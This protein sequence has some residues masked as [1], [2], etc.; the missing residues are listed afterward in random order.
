M[1]LFSLG[2]RQFRLEGKP[3][4]GRMLAEIPEVCLGGGEPRAVDA[5]LLAR[6]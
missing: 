3:Q 5:R 1:A 4:H 2:A 6:A